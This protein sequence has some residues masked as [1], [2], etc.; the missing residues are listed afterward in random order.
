M[1]ATASEDTGEYRTYGDQ[2]ALISATVQVLT[3][4]E[5]AFE[6]QMRIAR[7][8][9]PY[10]TAWIGVFGLD[11][12]KCLSRRLARHR[13]IDAGCILKTVRH[14]LAPVF[15]CGEIECKFFCRCGASCCKYCKN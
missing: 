6:A 7:S 1:T 2:E 3:D 5:M 13:H 4:R 10:V 8:A 11:L 9:P 12:R 15:L 14:Q